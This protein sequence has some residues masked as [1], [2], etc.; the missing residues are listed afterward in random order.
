MGVCYGPLHQDQGHNYTQADVEADM[1][2]IARHFKRIRTYSMQN[3]NQYNIGAASK[4][5][6]KVCLGT[7]VYHG[8]WAQTQSEIDL[9]L[10]QA[11]NSPGTV[12]HLIL[13][14]EVDRQD[15]QKLEPSE[16]MQA[17]KYAQGKTSSNP[18]LVNIPVTTCFSGT[19]LQQPNSPW[20][21]VVDACQQVV[22]LTIYPWYGGAQPGNIDG[23]MQWSYN[24]GMQQVEAQGK[25]VVIGE[26]GWP[27]A[28]GRETTVQ[29]EALNYNV[30]NAWVQGKN[31][32]SKAFEAFWFEMFDEPW[33]T[34]EGP[35]GPHW[36]LY[37][38]GADPVAKFPL[39]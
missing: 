36:G 34:A 30:T 35:Q 17:L 4:N 26:I 9:A 21:G 33:K 15:T 11:T 27:S 28:G 12:V 38:S 25:Q 22:Y 1:A 10:K 13:G 37:T 31:F 32:L 24:N 20:I 18:T 6:V 7:W 19:V 2:I 39:P 29:N 3:P 16:V 5:G 23:N 14:N 8:N